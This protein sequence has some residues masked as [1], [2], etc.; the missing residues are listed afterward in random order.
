[1]NWYTPSYSINC[2]GVWNWHIDGRNI[3]LQATKFW[4]YLKL[5]NRESCVVR[6]WP[7]LLHIFLW[8]INHHFLR[9]VNEKA[10]GTFYVFIFLIYLVSDKEN[11]SCTNYD[12]L[13]SIIKS[14]LELKSSYTINQALLCLLGIGA[15]DKIF[16]QVYDNISILGLAQVNCQYSHYETISLWDNEWFAGLMGCFF[17]FYLIWMIVLYMLVFYIYVIVFVMTYLYIAKSIIL[18][19]SLFLTGG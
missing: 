9:D 16:S 14:C 18:F 19:A 11:I 7:P 13:N 2:F 15:Q 17:I 5:W 3:E 4:Q 10:S 8:V 1:M 6:K 12:R